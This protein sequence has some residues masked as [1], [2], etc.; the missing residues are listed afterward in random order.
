MYLTADPESQRYEAIRTNL[1]DAFEQLS[2]LDG[3]PLARE[4]YPKESVYDGPYLDEAP[5]IVIDKQPHVNI[6]ENLGG[7]TV[8][9]ADDDSWNGVNRREGLFAAV[10][11][12]F[13][14][15]T[16]SGL[17]ILDFAPTLL[18]MHGQ[19]VPRDMDGEVRTDIFA[20]DSTPAT[21]SPTY[22]GTEESAPMGQQ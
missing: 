18:H 6:R 4:V 1:I 8:F 20:A 19:A 11:P 21:K 12:A 22:R 14:E 16:V 10:G 3:R 2:G 15:G 7:E 5:D 13:T 17:S 9:A